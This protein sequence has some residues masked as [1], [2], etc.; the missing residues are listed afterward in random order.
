MFDFMGYVSTLY[1]APGGAAMVAV[2]FC[3]I[4]GVVGLGYTS[5]STASVKRRTPKST[6]AGLSRAERR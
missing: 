1:A 2:S 5:G 4:F 6:L 3:L